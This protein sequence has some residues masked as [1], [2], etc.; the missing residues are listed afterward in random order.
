MTKDM[1]ESTSFLTSK[2]SSLPI[3]PNSFVEA[4]QDAGWHVAMTEEFDAILTNSTWD[5]VPPSIN[6]IG[7]KWVYKVIEG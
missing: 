5:L 6:L 1:T 7:C 2:S 3:E 4:F